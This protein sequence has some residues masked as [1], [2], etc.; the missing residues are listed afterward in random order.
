MWPAKCRAPVPFPD[1]HRAFN[2]QGAAFDRGET[3]SGWIS[4][5]ASS[6]RSVRPARAPARPSP[7][8]SAGLMF[9]P[10]CAISPRQRVSQEKKT[11]P[12]PRCLPAARNDG[13]ITEIYEKRA[14]A[15]SLLVNLSALNSAAFGKRRHR[16]FGRGDVGDARRWGAF[17]SQIGARW[18]GQTMRM[19]GLLRIGTEDGPGGALVTHL[20]SGVRGLLGVLWLIPFA[21]GRVVAATLFGRPAVGDEAEHRIRRVGARR[22]DLRPKRATRRLSWASDEFEHRRW[23]GAPRGRRR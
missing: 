16:I 17:I 13:R 23:S 20:R 3:F 11:W 5:P 4:R 14:R 18:R 7:M 12:Q 19:R 2:R 8:P 1:D 21:G 6:G 9:P 10:S 15:S 22:V